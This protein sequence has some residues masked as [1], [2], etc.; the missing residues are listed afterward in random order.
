MLDDE[1]VS[2]FGFTHE[3]VISLSTEEV[4]EQLETAVWQ[5]ARGD[6]RVRRYFDSYDAPFV[7]ERRSADGDD[8]IMLGGSKE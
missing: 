4:V 2:Y 8:N 5:H 3:I 7:G 1:R 6:R